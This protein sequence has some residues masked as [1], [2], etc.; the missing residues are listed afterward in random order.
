MFHGFHVSSVF[1]D[2]FL[3]ALFLVTEIHGEKIKRERQKEAKNSLI[4]SLN[5]FITTNAKLKKIITHIE[6]KYLN[7]I[8]LYYIH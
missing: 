4:V 5:V 6:E 8:H 2:I 3:L 7:I 1:I